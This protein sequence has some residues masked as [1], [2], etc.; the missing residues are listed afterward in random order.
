MGT[1]NLFLFEM[2]FKMKLYSNL[3][4]FTFYFILFY[5][6]LVFF[7]SRAAPAAYGGSQ[8]RGQ[9]GAI[10]IGLRQNNSNMESKPCLWP[11]P[12]V[13]AMMDP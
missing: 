13:T 10:A 5:F 6:F 8:A 2:D 3:H 1:P 4:I 7:F 9:I 12:Q 11:T